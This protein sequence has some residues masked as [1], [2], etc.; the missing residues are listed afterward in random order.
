MKT[1]AKRNTPRRKDRVLIVLHLTRA[2]HRRLAMAASGAG[3]SLRRWVRE[4]AL[5]L[6]PPLPRR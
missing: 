3:M 6:S 4:A 1:R 2:E 5:E